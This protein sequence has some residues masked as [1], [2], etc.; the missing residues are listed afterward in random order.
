MTDRHAGY[1]VVLEEDI[2]EDDAKAVI[3]ALK[4][5]KGVLT[6]KP[7]ISTPEI[8]IATNRAKAEMARKLWKV[9]QED[10]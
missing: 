8:I 6:V 5:I 2:R 3:D 7:I 4:M 10:F 9:L 1:V